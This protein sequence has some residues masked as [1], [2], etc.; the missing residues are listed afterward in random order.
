MIISLSKFESTIDIQIVSRGH[1]YF[2]NGTVGDLKQIKNDSI[3]LLYRQIESELMPVIRIGERF[4]LDKVF[5][6][7]NTILKNEE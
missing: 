3:E 1:D 7:F 6:R 2:S 5:E 4:D